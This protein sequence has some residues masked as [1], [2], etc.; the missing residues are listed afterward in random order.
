MKRTTIK[1]IARAAQVSPAAVSF[2]LNDKPGVSAQTRARIL[3][4][5]SAMGWAP[6]SYARALSA[7]VSQTIGLVIPKPTTSQTSE[8]FYFNFM[9]G[10]QTRLH[11]DGYQ[12]V[13]HL[14]ADF[15]DEL[16]TYRTWWAQRKVDAV[17]VVNPQASDKRAELLHELDLP[18]VFI[19]N[20][21]P[22]ASAVL[23]N[24]GEM[25]AE[26]AKH[27]VAQGCSSVAYICGAST[28]LHTQRRINALKSY[29][30]EEVLN[31]KI[32]ANTEFTEYAGYIETERFLANG[33]APQALIFEN[34][35][36]ALGGL[37]ALYD[38]NLTPGQDM[39]LISCEDS[40][41]CRVVK[42]AISAINRNPETLGAHAAELLVSVLKGAAP[43][44]VTEE[45]PTVIV[46]A[47]SATKIN[48]R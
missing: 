23:A 11:Q 34:E 8:R 21:M 27:L 38:N 10:L 19:G 33:I 24:D 37:Q 44:T 32:A 31:L 25:M 5:A 26:I 40:P 7:A 6:N 9:V 42:P 28:R 35:V 1:D 14:A 22:H 20:T 16:E 18:A 43:H 17:V 4:V 12:L 30:K 29:A 15:V 36:L 3:E 45:V 2:A 47:S 39:L 13:L 48:A 46:R 41:I